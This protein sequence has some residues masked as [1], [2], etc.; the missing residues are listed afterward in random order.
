MLEIRAD[1]NGVAMLKVNGAIKNAGNA[2]LRISATERPPVGRHLVVEASEGIN[3]AFAAVEG[4]TDLL[5]LHHA[6]GSDKVW[7]LSYN[8]GTL[9]L[10][11]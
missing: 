3:G 2:T 9:L 6:V 1:A 5:R 8:L 10:V 4:E 11:K 7:L